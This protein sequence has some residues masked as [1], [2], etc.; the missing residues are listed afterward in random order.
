MKPARPIPFNEPCFIGTEVDYLAQAAKVNKKISGD[1]PFTKKCTDFFHERYAPSRALLT[2]SCTDALEM[3]ALL[4][5]IKPGDEV[6]VPSFTF[7]SSANPFALR[8][9]RLVFV[10]SREDEPNIS[11]DRI[12]E[13]ITPRTRAIVVVHYAGFACEMDRILALADSY[14]IPVVEDAAQ[15]I[16]SFHR[17]RRLGTLGHFGTLSFHETKN[18]VCG[19]GG[20]I[21]INRPEFVHQAEIIREK[22]TN[23][24]AFFRGEVA[25]Y[26]WVDIG[27]SFLPSELN[28]AYL[29][30]QLEAVD[31]I[32]ARRVAIWNRYRERLQPLQDRN[33]ALLPVIPENATVNGH[34]FY[35]LCE[36][37]EVRTRLISSLKESGIMA[38]FHYIPLHSSGYFTEL[39]DGRSLPNCDRFSDTL[40]RLP[41]YF[42]MTDEIVDY[43]ADQTL[44]FFG[45]T[46]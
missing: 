16:E 46:A 26:S 41:L 28:A 7:V 12:A 44:A 39:H 42:A 14:G 35:L 1:G 9:A 2:T 33:L 22:G 36:N 40:V 3:S 8:G 32:Q 19:E 25:K 18:I 11:V 15:A 27:S 13:A 17:G 21:L 37:L 6:I 23:R 5:G 43:I 4:L 38:T 45:L 31:A 10:D 34:L 29:F 30:G 20:L 24:S